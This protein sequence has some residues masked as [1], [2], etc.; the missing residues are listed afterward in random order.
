M[1]DFVQASLNLG[2]NAYPAF[3]RGF[4]DFTVMKLHFPDSSQYIQEPVIYFSQ[5]EPPPPQKSLTCKNYEIT[6]DSRGVEN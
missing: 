1:D 2:G 5:H 6:C 3:L 4:V